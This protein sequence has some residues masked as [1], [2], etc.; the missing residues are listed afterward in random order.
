MGY[1][2]TTTGCNNDTRQGGSRW[3]YGEA[4]AGSMDT[5]SETAKDESQTG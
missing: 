2:K 4:N 3:A 1:S 5:P